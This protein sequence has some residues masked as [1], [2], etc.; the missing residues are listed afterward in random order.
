MENMQWVMK[1]E[2]TKMNTDQGKQSE[3]D[4]R[5]KGRRKEPSLLTWLSLVFT[6]G[7]RLKNK[8]DLFFLVVEEQ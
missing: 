4:G 5:W 6:D 8:N 1:P 2:N 7:H 3:N